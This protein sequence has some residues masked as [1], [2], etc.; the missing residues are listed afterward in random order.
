MAEVNGVPICSWDPWPEPLVTKSQLS[1]AGFKPG[2]LRAVVR[3]S[4]SST[5]DGYLHLFNPDEGIRRKPPTEK[6][7]A[8]RA[9]RK[10]DELKART[11]PQCGF[12]YSK[13]HIR[14]NGGICEECWWGVK[15]TNDRQAVAEIVAQVLQGGCVILD[16]ETTGLYNAEPVE[17][18]V[19]DHTGAVLFNSRVKPLRPERLSVKGEYGETATD[20][21]GITAED[22]ANAPSFGEIYPALYEALHGKHVVIYNEAFD[23]PLLTA[24][25]QEWYCPSF[26]YEQSSCAMLWYAQFCGDWSSYFQSYRWQ[27][28]PGGD[29]SA[30]GDARATLEVLREMA[31][32]LNEKTQEKNHAMPNV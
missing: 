2:P 8:A 14:L 19:L 32:S 11:C 6:Q 10:A 4:K 5:G 27:P 13:R 1:K 9:K 30:L 24:T 15:A 28:L 16:M 12:V 23:L 29:H 20:I 25:R 31:A 26:G 18:A 17:I 21:H 7:I 3:Y 22:L